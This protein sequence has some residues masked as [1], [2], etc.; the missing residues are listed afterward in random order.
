VHAVLLVRCLIAL[1]L[2]SSSFMKY[3][4]TA[5][6]ARVGGSYAV[7]AAS[8]GATSGTFTE[9]NLA[10]TVS[11]V[12]VSSGGGQSTTIGTAFPTL[13]TAAVEDSHGNPVLI[14]ALA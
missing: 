11:Q 9:T 2:M 13:L 3:T 10:R 8:V 12:V 5:T 1:D 4:R 14:P 7:T 6:P